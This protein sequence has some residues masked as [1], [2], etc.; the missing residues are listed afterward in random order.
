MEN[1]LSNFINRLNKLG[2]NL[3]IVSNYPWIYIN[4]ING[5]KV[6]EK[7]HSEYGF[8]IA[9]LPIKLN[10]ELEFTDVGEIFKLI[11]KYINVEGCPNCGHVLIEKLSGVKCSKCEYWFCF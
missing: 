7:F 6:T 10:D 2:I 3:N 8:T 5:I 4:S 1:K 11:R 9:F